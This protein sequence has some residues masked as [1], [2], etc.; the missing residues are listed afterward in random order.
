ML[1]HRDH[2]LVDVQAL[3]GIADGGQL[4]ALAQRAAQGI[5]DPLRL[6]PAGL[7]AGKQDPA[8][9]RVVAL[10]EI[11]AHRRILVDPA[12][13]L[14]VPGEEHVGGKQRRGTRAGQEIP[15]GE[16]LEF[17]GMLEEATLG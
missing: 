12:L 10:G 17:G 13:R 5:Q 7:V 4:A 3:V 16:S 14:D 8:G 6:L 9:I 15:P 2:D 1:D 11:V